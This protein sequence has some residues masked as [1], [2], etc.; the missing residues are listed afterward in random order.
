MSPPFDEDDEDRE[1]ILARRKRFIAS[2]LAGLA[3]VSSA[4]CSTSQTCLRIALPE[5]AQED[6]TDASDAADS[7]PQPCLSRPPDDVPIVTDAPDAGPQPCLTPPL[8]VPD[9]PE[10]PDT[11]PDAP[12]VGPQPCLTPPL[13]VPATPDAGDDDATPMPCLSL[14]LD[15]GPRDDDAT[16]MP[17]LSPL[18]PDGSL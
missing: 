15:A 12:D 10:V 16:P 3:M 8:D 13:D 6:V 7:T 14:P 17:C 11:G 18:P 4:N 2:A 5:D 9:V 1:A